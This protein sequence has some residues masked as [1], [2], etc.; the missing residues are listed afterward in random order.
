M[1]IEEDNLKGACTKR[2]PDKKV[3]ALNMFI[4]SWK[5]FAQHMNM[6]AM[7]RPSSIICSGTTPAQQRALSGP[8]KIS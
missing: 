5:S 1:L 4:A 3:A 6:N 2:T 8:L 7:V